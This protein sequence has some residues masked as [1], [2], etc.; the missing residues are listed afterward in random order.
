MIFLNP[1]KCWISAAT[2]GTMI[3]ETAAAE[4]Y[5]AIEPR[6]VLPPEAFYTPLPTQGVYALQISAVIL[7]ARRTR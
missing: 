5:P 3:K 1:V 7:S 2:A 4:V 6:E